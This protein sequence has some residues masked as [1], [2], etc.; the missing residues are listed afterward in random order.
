M[1]LSTL[2][3]VTSL[4]QGAAYSRRLQTSDTRPTRPNT[5]DDRLS[6]SSSSRPN[7]NI[8]DDIMNSNSRPGITRPENSGPTSGINARNNSN[9]DDEIYLPNDD[10]YY[11]PPH[12]LTA[13]V[14]AA[15]N[16]DDWGDITTN[17][18]DSNNTIVSTPVLVSEENVVSIAAGQIHSVL[19]TDQGVL[20]TGG[21]G[22]G[23]GRNYSEGFAPITDVH[24]P[25]DSRNVFNGDTTNKTTLAKEVSTPPRFAKIYASQ[26]FTI[27][28]DEKGY[29]WS[30]GSNSNGQ[31]CLGDNIDRDRMEM[32]NPDSYNG[33]GNSIS[34]TQRTTF[35]LGNHTQLTLPPKEVL[36]AKLDETSNNTQIIDVALGERHT[37]FLRQDGVVFACGWNEF[38][39]LG[40]DST[41]SSILSPSR[42]ILNEAVDGITAGRGSSYLLTENNTIFVTG[43]NFYGQLCLGDKTDRSSLSSMDPFAKDD[44]LDGSKT[45][46]DAIAAGK[47]SL[48]ILLSN[49]QVLSCGDNTHGQLGVG[50][51]STLIDIPTVIPLENIVNVFSGPLSYNAFF[52]QQNGTARAAGYNGG[53]QLGIGD[54]INHD[55]PAVV[56][57]SDLANIDEE[58]AS[59]ISISSSN[60]HT[61]FLGTE[62]TFLC[63]GSSATASPTATSTPTAPPTLTAKP[64]VSHLPTSSTNLPTVSF[65][66]NNSIIPSATYAPSSEPSSEPNTCHGVKFQHTYT[67]LLGL[68]V[69]FGA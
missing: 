14:F 20:L 43:T 42:M 62:A 69:Y 57:C 58:M 53:G 32:V 50:N 10:E 22:L 21:Q 33:L 7:T 44:G 19:L 13:H 28:L 30:T 41:E 47:S 27:A 39:Q 34:T 52:V 56:A 4:P 63:D 2:I 38:G 51:N 3:I 37:L 68:A 36:D 5:D 15:G 55:T 8:D 54:G 60:D 66:S 40:L 59:R 6:S 48:Y 45:K 26:Y 61:L 64:T 25:A 24:F 23:L 17:S 1:K 16:S 35:E 9:T 67:Y 65:E 46:V 18:S 12:S 29:L 31:L 49:G 11:L